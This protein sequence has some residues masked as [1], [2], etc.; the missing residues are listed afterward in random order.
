MAPWEIGTLAT[1]GLTL[2]LLCVY[3]L[4][5]YQLLLL[6]RRW[7]K[8]TAQPSGRFET[9]PMVTVQLPLF[10]EPLVAER[11]IRAVCALDWPQER[12]EIQVLD[13]S[14]DETTE[15]VARVVD[16]FRARGVDIRHIHR[17][18]RDGFK[19]GALAH[20]LSLA[21]GEFTLILD[22]DFLPPADLLRRMID[23]MAD[24]RIGMVQ[25]R[26]DHLNRSESLLTRVQALMLDGHFVV[27]HAARH[28]AGRFF[29]FNG[30]AGLWRRAAIDSAGGWQHDTLTEDLDLSYRAQLAGWK[31]VYL[32]EITV[33]AELPADMEAFKSQQHRWTKGSVQTALKLLGRI[34]RA[35]LPWPVKVESTFHLTDNFAYIFMFLLTLLMG[36]VLFIRAAHGLVW[37]FLI[38]LPLL[39]AG[40]L[41]VS[42]FYLYTLAKTGRL[43]PREVLILPALLALGIGMC[44]NNGRAVLEALRGHQSPFVRT[45]KSGSDSRRAGAGGAAACRL[46]SRRLPMIEFLLG[47]YGLTVVAGAAVLW[48]P[49][50]LPFLAL[51]PAGYLS[52]VCAPLLSSSQQRCAGRRGSSASSASE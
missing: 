7:A 4:H 51:F 10:N 8:E 15:V 46:I 45:P 22:A 43:R 35:P 27:E 11:L 16:E 29:N 38:D 48:Q 21:R 50:A 28:R 52:V 18:T 42:T 17:E 41:S 32:P 9:E 2:G 6:H 13:D 1:Y 14:T 37:Q 47:L 19:A 31:F 44:V 39:L 40:T 33:P 30:T 24:P 12:M 20:G 36:P 23:H 26:W 34:W 3:G 25:A 49:L 5:R